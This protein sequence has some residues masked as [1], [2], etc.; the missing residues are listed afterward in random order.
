M[1]LDVLVSG[2]LALTYAEIGLALR[3]MVFGFPP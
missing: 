1:S 2:N 3:T